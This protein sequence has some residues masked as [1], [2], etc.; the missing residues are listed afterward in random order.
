MKAKLSSLSHQYFQLHPIPASCQQPSSLL[1]G[2]RMPSRQEENITSSEGSFLE[3]STS[4]VNAQLLSSEISLHTTLKKRDIYMYVYMY[5]YMHKHIHIL[6]KRTSAWIG[7]R[8]VLQQNQ[9]SFPKSHADT[10]FH[11]KS[12]KQYSS[13]FA[14]SLLSSSPEA[15]LCSP[16]VAHPGVSS[17]PN[18]QKPQTQNVWKLMPWVIPHLF[19]IL[20]SRQQLFPVVWHHQVHNSLGLPTVLGSRW[21]PASSGQP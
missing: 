14:N 18:F 19:H 20:P 16:P 4:L 10:F 2:F 5:T 7:Y 6:F 3:W 15:P 8:G 13:A 1:S 12:V 9:D 11:L 21:F 17:S